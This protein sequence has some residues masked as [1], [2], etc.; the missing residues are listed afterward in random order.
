[1]T[2]STSFNKFQSNKYQ[3]LVGINIENFQHVLGTE[4]QQAFKT[5]QIRKCLTYTD[6]SC[7]SY[8]D[9]RMSG[10]SL[11]HRQ[12]GKGPPSLES[13]FLPTILHPHP[14]GL[15]SGSLPPWCWVHQFQAEHQS[16]TGLAPESKCYDVYFNLYI[17]DML[18][19]LQANNRAWKGPDNKAATNVCGRKPDITPS[20]IYLLESSNLFFSFAITFSY[21]IYFS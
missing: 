3:I 16:R 2:S 5:K 11:Q 10:D 14:A 18:L 12:Q 19:I 15:Q 1:M 9:K 7:K 13:L 4:R 6:S 17:S 20:S 8:S 21:L